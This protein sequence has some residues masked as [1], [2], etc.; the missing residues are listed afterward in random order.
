[1]AKKWVAIVLSFSV[2]IAASILVYNYLFGLFLQYAMDGPFPGQVKPEFQ[3]TF[4]VKLYAQCFFFPFALVCLPFIF[5]AFAAKWKIGKHNLWI[6]ILVME[7]VVLL[8]TLATAPPDMISRM[9]F[10]ILWQLP[11]GVNVLFLLWTIARNQK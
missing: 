7:L 10:F 3:T 2:V 1:M 6:S 11:I 5:S 8:L 4:N 9:M